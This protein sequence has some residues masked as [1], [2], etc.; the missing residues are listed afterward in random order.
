MIYIAH[1]GNLTGPDPVNENTISHIQNALNNNYNV[2]ID[3]WYKDFQLYLG[4]DYPQHLVELDFL[5]ENK[6]KLWC[7]CKN[8]EALEY[9]LSFDIHCF[10]HDKD[11]ATLTSLKYVWTYPSPG[12]HITNSICV[13]PEWYEFKI[14]DIK[15]CVAI[16]TDYVY[17]CEKIFNF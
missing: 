12:L 16:C 5:L 10:V 13:L 2:E 6:T 4:H 17:K 7:H 3:V 15:K 8:L 14:A 11:I 9:L 1:R